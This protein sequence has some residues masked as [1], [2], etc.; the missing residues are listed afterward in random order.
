LV[1][2]PLSRIIH[3]DPGEHPGDPIAQALNAGH[4]LRDRP[5]EVEDRGGARRPVRLTLF[6][7]RDRDKVVGGVVIVRSP[8]A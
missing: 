2:S 1:N 7:L 4:D 8:S 6:P 3:L 5:A